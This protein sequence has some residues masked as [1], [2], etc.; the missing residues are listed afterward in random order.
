MPNPTSLCVALMA[1]MLLTS[2][3]MSTTYEEQ[4]IGTIGS[5][6]RHSGLQ[7]MHDGSVIVVTGDRGP[8]IV[9]NLQ[10]KY[11]IHRFHNGKKD[12]LFESDS[13]IHDFKANEHG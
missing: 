1:S 4:Y 3:A 12:V 7:L 13:A 2:P 11:S 6:A 5:V 9:P 10:S 8:N